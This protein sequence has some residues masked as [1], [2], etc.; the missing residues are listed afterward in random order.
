MSIQKF[1]ATN[2]QWAAVLRVKMPCWCQW[3]EEN[4][5]TGSNS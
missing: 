1:E 3:S 2:I 5:Q 4:G